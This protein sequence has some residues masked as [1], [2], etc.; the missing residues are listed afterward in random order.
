M[1]ARDGEDKTRE[2]F[3]RKPTKVEGSIGEGEKIQQV[4]FG[5]ITYF[6]LALIYLFFVILKLEAGGDFFLVLT[7]SGL[8]YAAG[9]NFC[10]QLGLGHTQRKEVRAASYSFT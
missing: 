3:D 6:L 2:I 1:Y 9:S 5:H 4:D 10:G 8:V 7:Q